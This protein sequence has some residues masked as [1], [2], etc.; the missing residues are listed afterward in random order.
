[1]VQ[2]PW[3]ATLNGVGA[4]CLDILSITVR[5]STVR[6]SHVGQGHHHLPLTTRI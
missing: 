2:G 5:A 4:L 1:M 6:A 3:G